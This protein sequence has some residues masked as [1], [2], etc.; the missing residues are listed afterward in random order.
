MFVHDCRIDRN[1]RT[2]I[3]I[4]AG[5]R[6]VRIVDTSAERND[7]GLGC[8]GASDGFNTDASVADIT[9]ERASAMGN[10]RDGFDLKAPNVT[11][12]GAVARDNGCSGVKVW[13][14]S[15]LENALLEGNDVGVNVGAPAGAATVLQNCT[16]LGNGLGVR[17]LSSAQ[18]VLIHNSIIAGEGKAISYAIPVELIEDHNMACTAPTPTERL[19]GADRTGRRRAYLRRRHQRGLAGSTTADKG[20]APSRSSRRARPRSAARAHAPIARRSIAALSSIATG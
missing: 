18:T 16:L 19:I 13:A 11:V 4:F 6:R 15:Y 2:G 1:Y 5:A 7:D 10:S 3:R 20:R 14:G 9:F 8:D 12:L 17:A